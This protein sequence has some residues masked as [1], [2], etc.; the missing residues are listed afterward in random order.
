MYDFKFIKYNEPLMTSLV[1]SLMCSRIVYSI[2]EE[3]HNK[4]I[5]SYCRYQILICEI[6]K[7]VTCN[8]LALHG[9]LKFVPFI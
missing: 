4:M 8:L 6:F 3:V 7:K 2:L 9:F 5:I 1:L